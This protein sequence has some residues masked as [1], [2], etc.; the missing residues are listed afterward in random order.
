MTNEVFDDDD[1][2]K[3]RREA[4]E[5]RNRMETE[6]WQRLVATEDG[7]LVLRSILAQCHIFQLSYTRGDQLETAYREGA[8]RV[9]LWLTAKLGEIDPEAVVKVVHKTERA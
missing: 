2:A 3:E 1:L 8:R 6:A 5:L 7:V 4:A 9:G